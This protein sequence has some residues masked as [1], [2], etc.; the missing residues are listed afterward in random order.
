MIIF[1]L[2]QLLKDIGMSQKELS[3]RTGIRYGTISK[4]C[5]GSAPHITVDNLNTICNATKSK[6]ADILDH[7]PD[8]QYEAEQEA[9][10]S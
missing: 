4:M 9:R 6:P 2:K 3:R 7:D 10:L 1:K 5:N 8:P